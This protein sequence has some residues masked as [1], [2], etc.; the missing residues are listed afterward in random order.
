MVKKI[1]DLDFEMD[2]KI[3]NYIL[4]KRSCDKNK[5]GVRVKS[6]FFE[7]KEEIFS[8][9]IR[10]YLYRFLK[11]YKVD[12]IGLTTHQAAKKIREILK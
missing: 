6:R 5:S 9:S 11:G 7:N 3:Y 1:F 2:G 12:T 8:S 10:S 4:E